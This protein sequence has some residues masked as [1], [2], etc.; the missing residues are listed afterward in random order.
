MKNAD[1]NAFPSGTYNQGGLTKREYIATKAMQGLIARGADAN[2]SVEEISERAVAYA[3]RLLV[4]LLPS[5]E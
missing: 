3:D 1:E 5:Y 2:F 4:A